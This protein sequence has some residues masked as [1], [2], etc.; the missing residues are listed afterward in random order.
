M[1]ETR[2]PLHY[3]DQV[4]LFQYEVIH[5]ELEDSSHKLRQCRRT[6]VI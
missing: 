1:D 6:A 5:I 2:L 4:E 3:S